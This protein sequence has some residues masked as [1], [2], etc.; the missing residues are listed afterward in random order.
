MYFIQGIAAF[1]LAW[2]HL[3]RL[4]SLKAPRKPYVIR[5]AAPQGHAL[6]PALPGFAAKRLYAAYGDPPRLLLGVCLLAGGIPRAP[7]QFMSKRLYAYAAGP[8]LGGRACLAALAGCGSPLQQAGF[9]LLA[10]FDALQACGA[11]PSGTARKPPPPAAC[12]QGE[13]PRASYTLHN[14][15]PGNCCI[16]KPA[17]VLG[18]FWTAL[19]FVSGQ[20]T[21]VYAPAIGLGHKRRDPEASLPR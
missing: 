2:T 16:C 14:C 3:P 15:I 7:Y 4:A 12:W 19:R 5:Q 8:W 9:A 10:H 13:I 1:P 20:Y 21:P 11:F 17:D 18:A 6:F